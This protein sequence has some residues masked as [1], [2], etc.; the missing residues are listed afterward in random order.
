MTRF[1]RLWLA[2]LA[3]I[4]ASWLPPNRRNLPTEVLR[5]EEEK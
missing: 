4:V 5:K 1:L 3:M 2:C